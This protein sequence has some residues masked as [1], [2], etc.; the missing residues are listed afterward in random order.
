MANEAISIL[1][2]CV[3]RANPSAAHS[4]L[5]TKIGSVL[6]TRYLD[7]IQPAA[8]NC[9]EKGGSISLTKYSLRGTIALNFYRL[10]K[11]PRVALGASK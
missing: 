4:L 1:G 10:A 9:I 5:L 7:A 8:G 2:E 6:E 3:V 11:A